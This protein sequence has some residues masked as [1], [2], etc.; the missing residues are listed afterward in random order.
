V[1]RRPRSEARTKKH[2]GFSRNN[3]TLLSPKQPAQNATEAAVRGRSGHDKARAAVGAY[4]RVSGPRAAYER[5]HQ[6]SKPHSHSNHRNIVTTSI[7]LKRCIP[8]LGRGGGAFQWWG[9]APDRQTGAGFM[10]NIF[11]NAVT[12]VVLPVPVAKRWELSVLPNRRDRQVA[13]RAGIL[14]S[15]SQGRR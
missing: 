12:N 5:V 13:A 7:I 9:G 10:M 15:L 6:N 1:R 14:R 8:G 11:M 2:Y 3:P 4:L